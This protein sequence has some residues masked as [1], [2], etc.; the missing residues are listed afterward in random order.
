MAEA[1]SWRLSRDNPIFRVLTS[2]ILNLGASIWLHA[3]ERYLA[4]V[5]PE[6]EKAI[7]KA[8][9]YLETKKMGTD[10]NKLRDEFKSMKISA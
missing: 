10:F 3:I 8:K 4:K 9:N 6:A 5:N 7:E 1:L 2:T